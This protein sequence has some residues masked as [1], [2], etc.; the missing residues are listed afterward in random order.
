MLGRR[1]GYAQALTH[2]SQYRQAPE[3]LSSHCLVGIFFLS[4]S[5]F[6]WHFACPL[7]TFATL[8]VEEI[9]KKY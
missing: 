7:I 3:H 8:L 1:N 9:C 2:Q 5:F 4:S 6:F